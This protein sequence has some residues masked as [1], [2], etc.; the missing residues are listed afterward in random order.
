ME[1]ESSKRNPRLSSIERIANAMD[2]AI[3]LV[4]EHLT[5]EIHL[6]VESQG[7]VATAPSST[8]AEKYY[9]LRGINLIVYY[10]G[11]KEDAD[12]TARF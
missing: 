1:I 9:K 6:Y 4:L 11:F 10:T 5:P 2:H 12:A 8:R 3:R 7:C